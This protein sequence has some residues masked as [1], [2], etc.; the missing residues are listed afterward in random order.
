M[1]V[2]LGAHR[3]E[4]REGSQQIFGIAQSI[5]HPHYNPRSV[6]ND[7]RLL[8]VSPA[9][10]W[11]AQTCRPG[12]QVTHPRAVQEGPGVPHGPWVRRSH[13]GSRH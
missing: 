12:D 4:E 3:L 2:V 7:I 5:A 1:R 6:D 9:R 8:Q 10:H 11:S 13:P